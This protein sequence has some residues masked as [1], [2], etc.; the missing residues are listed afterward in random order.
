MKAHRLYV[1]TFA[2]ALLAASIAGCGKSA[3]PVAPNAGLSQ[4]DADE[5]AQQVSATVSGQSNASMGATSAAPVS[6]SRG[7]SA[8]AVMSDTTFTIGAITWTLTRNWYDAGGNAQASYNPVTT[9]RMIASARGTGSISGTNFQ[10]SY[11]GYGLLDVSGVS[12]LQDT[13]TTQA[14]HADTLQSTFTSINNVTRQFYCVQSSNWVDVRQLKPVSSNPW[15]LSGTATF[16]VDAD[17]LRSSNRGDVEAHLVATVVI[18]FNGTRYP[19]VTID[20]KYSYQFDLATGAII[21]G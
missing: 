6:G 10:G 20:G 11:G 2:L 13:L 21:R 5:V 12:M 3:S 1:P 9:V 19:N 17:R 4:S 16:H 7:A 8:Q 18:T 14:T 15:P